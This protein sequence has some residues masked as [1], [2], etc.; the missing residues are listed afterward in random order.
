MEWMLQS[1]EVRSKNGWKNKTDSDAYKWPTLQLN[2]DRIEKYHTN[3]CQKKAGV[4]ILVSEK[5]HS[6]KY[7]TRH[8]GG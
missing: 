5:I 4:A 3:E 7:I 2:N 1:R 6:K 8:R